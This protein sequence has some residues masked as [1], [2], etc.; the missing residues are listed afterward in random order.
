MTSANIKVGDII[1]INKDERVPADAVLLYT[2]EKN[3]SIFIR[4]DQL[5]GETDWK[6]RKAVAITQRIKEPT[7]LNKTVGYILANP[8]NEMIYDFKGV[9]E[10]SDPANS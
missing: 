2:T 1:K 8:P 4:T 6:L 10:C 9:F 5:D 7:Q 3:G